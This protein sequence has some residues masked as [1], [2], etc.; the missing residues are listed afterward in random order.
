MR[1]TY[2]GEVPGK[3]EGGSGS[4]F[5]VLLG[6]QADGTARG[7]GRRREKDRCEQPQAR[8]VLRKSRPDP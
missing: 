3:G 6:F 4:T 5:Q 2:L 1:E 7:L 8:T